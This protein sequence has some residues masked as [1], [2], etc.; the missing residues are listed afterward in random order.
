MLLIATIFELTSS[1][2]KAFLPSLS[3]LAS[4]SD[5]PINEVIKIKH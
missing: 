2:F 1:I 4:S 5:G 3:P